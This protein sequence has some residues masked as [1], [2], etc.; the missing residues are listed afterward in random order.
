[1][2]WVANVISSR[3]VPTAKK[4]LVLPVLTM[5][6]ETDGGEGPSAAVEICV[7]VITV[8]LVCFVSVSTL[9]LLG[10]PLFQGLV[11]SSVLLRSDWGRSGRL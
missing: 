3:G 10:V 2:G 7:L 9:L 8:L 4:W 11:A 1:M 5:A 6:G